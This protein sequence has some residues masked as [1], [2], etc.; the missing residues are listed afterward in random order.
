MLI[1]PSAKPICAIFIH[2]QI[3]IPDTEE[4]TKNELGKRYLKMFVDFLRKEQ[5]AFFA[6]YSLTSGIYDEPS[7]EYVAAGAPKYYMHGAVSFS[8][9]FYK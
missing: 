8:F 5:L 1:S 9:I 2:V 4:N 7:K 6:G 3:F